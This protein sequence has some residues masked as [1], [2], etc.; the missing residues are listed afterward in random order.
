MSPDARPAVSGVAADMAIVVT[1]G[2]VS[3]APTANSAMLGATSAR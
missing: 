1:A 2:S 3:P